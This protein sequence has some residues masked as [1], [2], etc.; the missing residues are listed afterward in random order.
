[1]SISETLST[2]YDNAT[3]S[4]TNA[5]NDKLSG[6]NNKAS[7][8]KKMYDAKVSRITDKNY[9]ERK[10]GESSIAKRLEANV[11]TKDGIQKK[12]LEG[13]PEQDKITPYLT[14]SSCNVSDLKSKASGMASNAVSGALG[15]L[16]SSVSKIKAFGVPSLKPVKKSTEV[17]EV[18]PDF[19][20]TEY[21]KATVKVTEGGFTEVIDN[22]KGNETSMKSNIAGTYELIL[23]DGTKQDK[24]VGD[25]ILLIDENWKISVGKDSVTIIKGEHHLQINKNSFINTNGNKSEIV[26]KESATL[27]K[28][29]VTNECQK[30]SYEKV[31]KNKEVD[32]SGNYKIKALTKTEEITGKS[33]THSSGTTQQTSGGG[34]HIFANGNVIM[35]GGSVNIASNG[36]SISIRKGRV[37]ING[38]FYVNGYPYGEFSGHGFSSTPDIEID[39]SNDLY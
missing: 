4:A 13:L 36:A 18:A 30:A 15:S 20:K 14:K 9:F 21:G 2:S 12:T 26:D 24:I 22:T 17:K 34:F 29:N 35:T 7:N 37:D 16:L 23:P 25:K 33:S 10:A 1:M 3:T 5:V 28:G 27:V 6:I 19:Q 31:G 32:I 8:L 39:E 38:P 11:P